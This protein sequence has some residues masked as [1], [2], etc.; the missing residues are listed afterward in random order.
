M[1]RGT[2]L[3][4]FSTHVPVY[5]MVP[6]YQNRVA[7]TYSY[8]ISW[9]NSFCFHSRAIY[10][11]TDVIVASPTTWGAY[12]TPKQ[13]LRLL[14]ASQVIGD[15]T[16]TESRCQL[17]FC[18]HEIE[19]MAKVNARIFPKSLSVIAWLHVHS[20]PLSYGFRWPE[21]VL[22]DNTCSDHCDF[23]ARLVALDISHLFMMF[24]LTISQ[25][26]FR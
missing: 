8:Y 18:C 24:E 21:L 20:V 15:L 26:W 12:Q 14:W 3:R 2:H 6:K 1:A 23:T 11:K 19:L 16:M 7:L 17:L 22:L 5:K 25:H 4:A 10:I 9:R 13:S